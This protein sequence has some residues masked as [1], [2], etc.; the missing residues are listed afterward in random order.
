MSKIPTAKEFLH[1][2]VSFGDI[3]G[4]IPYRYLVDNNV[5]I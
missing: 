2:M 3:K 5:S 1:Q 4:F